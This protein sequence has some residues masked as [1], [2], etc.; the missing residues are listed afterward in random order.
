[1]DKHHKI[2]SIAFDFFSFVN[3]LLLR[4]VSIRLSRVIHRSEF[5]RVLA[6]LSP[7]SNGH[8]LIRVGA[9]Q[10]GG[11]LVPDDLEEI[12]ACFSPGTDQVVEFEKYFFTRGVRCYLADASVPENPFNSPLVD[13]RKK[14]IS[15]FSCGDFLSLE[16]WIVDSSPSLPGDMVL[17]IDIE[18]WEYQALSTCPLS[19]LQKFRI[20]I[21][22]FHDFHRAVD[23]YFFRDLIAPII[24]K[25]SSAFDPVHIHPN[26][27]SPEFELHG[28]RCPQAFELTLHRKDRR[29]VDPPVPSIMELPH[30]LDQDNLPNK[31]PVEI[32]KDW[33]SHSPW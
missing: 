1:M 26:N 18:G 19:L 8:A 11:Y 21:I 33:P 24:A 31:S 13:F 29:H 9:T 3:R 22:E 15:G 6:W 23:R 16:D 27:A 17:Q 10:D 30:M 20:I 28:Y 25:L 4:A 5:K 2:K 32:S 12:V 14:Y 7:C